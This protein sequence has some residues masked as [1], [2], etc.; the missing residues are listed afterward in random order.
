MGMAY[1]QKNLFFAIP[2]DGLAL[3]GAPCPSLHHQT[4]LVLAHRWSPPGVA[5]RRGGGGTPPPAEEHGSHRGPDVVG[6]RSSPAG[7]G[8]AVGLLRVVPGDGVLVP[9]P[10]PAGT[11]I[12]QVGGP[13]CCTQTSVNKE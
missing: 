6:T 4:L 12:V 8:G 1:L 3:W 5:L 7:T 2:T 10:V 11:K 13:V 9:L